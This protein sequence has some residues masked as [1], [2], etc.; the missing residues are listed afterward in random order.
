MEKK[1]SISYDKEADVM[2]LSFGDPVNSE[3]E[4]VDSGIFAR[5]DPN[6]KE[7]TGLTVLNFSK[8]FD[9][10]PREVLIPMAR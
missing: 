8:K 10:K 5:F 1:I 7:L 6:T 2:Y 9:V 4:E 3:A